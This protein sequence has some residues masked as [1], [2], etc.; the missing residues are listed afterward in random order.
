MYFDEVKD[1]FCS[2]PARM[3]KGSLL[4]TSCFEVGVG[5]RWGGWSCIL[6]EGAEMG[7]CDLVVFRL[8]SMGM[9]ED[10]RFV[11]AVWTGGRCYEKKHGKMICGVKKVTD[12][13][14]LAVTPDARVPQQ[15]D[16][17]DSSAARSSNTSA[18][19]PG[20]LVLSRSHGTHKV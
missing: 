6:G 15:C 9:L 7:C 16:I 5:R 13:N 11:D 19:S 12:A 1:E 17:V 10:E 2:S 4:T 8:T 14:N 3:R 18:D 20:V